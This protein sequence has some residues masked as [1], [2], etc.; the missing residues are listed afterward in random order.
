[1]IGV[2]TV[3]R[4]LDAEGLITIVGACGIAIATSLKLGWRWRI[5]YVLALTLVGFLWTV[6]AYLHSGPYATSCILLSFA[7]LAFCV[8]AR[9]ANGLDR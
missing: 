9:R 2:N 5:P 1:M 4:A 3:L 8:Y 6:G 7:L